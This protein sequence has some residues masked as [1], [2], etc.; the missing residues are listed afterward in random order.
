MKPQ[1]TLV[2]LL[3]LIF[4]AAILIYYYVFNEQKSSTSERETGFALKDTAS[5]FKIEIKDPN[6]NN[7]ILMRTAKGWSF[8]NTEAAN[9]WLIRTVLE[10]VY[11]ISVKS[12][13]STTAKAQVTQLLSKQATQV[14][15]YDKQND[16]LKEYYFGGQANGLDGTFARLKGAKNPYIV[17]VDGFEGYLS[18]RFPTDKFLWKSRRIFKTTLSNVQSIAVNYAKGD[19][20]YVLVQQQPTRWYIDQKEVSYNNFV[21]KGLN[22]FKNGVALLEFSLYPDKTIISPE[23]RDS[24]LTQAKPFVHLT[25]TLNS[26]EKYNIA[27][28]ERLFRGKKE[29]SSYW[30]TLN[31]KKELAIA[32]EFAFGYWLH[33]KKELLK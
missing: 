6:K 2:L 14:S 3:I 17:S 22:Y 25:Y 15:L 24:V 31:D 23:R 20:S 4:V 21:K 8:D 19:S 27:L 30:A 33:A 29:L 1:K 10:T 7:I 16:L 18:T 26:G 13:V 9:E 32:Q 28:Y 5:I 12:P 11:H